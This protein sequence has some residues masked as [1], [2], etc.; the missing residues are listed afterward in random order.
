MKLETIID[1]ALK[2]IIR[3]NNELD[4]LNSKILVG[5]KSLL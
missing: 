3:K 2:V 5:D 1:M 4:E